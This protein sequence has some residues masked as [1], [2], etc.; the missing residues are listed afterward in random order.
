[1]KYFIIGE[2]ELCNSSKNKKKLCI[3]KKILNELTFCIK[4]KMN[5]IDKNN[6]QNEYY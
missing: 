3:F 6:M 2:N 5:S 4:G 1:M